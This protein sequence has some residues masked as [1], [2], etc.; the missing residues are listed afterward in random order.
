MRNDCNVCLGPVPVA[1]SPRLVMTSSLSVANVEA[2]HAHLE[3]VPSPNEPKLVL[4]LSRDGSTSSSAYSSTG[5][6][7]PTPTL[8]RSL[9]SNYSSS[10]SESLTDDDEDD[11]VGWVSPSSSEKLALPVIRGL[12]TSVLGREGA[13][14]SRCPS[15]GSDGGRYFERTSQ[16]FVKGL[17]PANH[18]DTVSLSD[19]ALPLTR[20]SA[21]P[22]I[23]IHPVASH[24]SE[25]TDP[26]QDDTPTRTSPLLS[27]DDT[28]S[29]Q[30]TVP[31]DP[32]PGSSLL[33]ASVD[34]P[35]PLLVLAFQQEPPSMRR[36]YRPTPIPK[37]LPLPTPEALSRA[38]L[39]SLRL[40]LS[41]PLPSIP[42]S[43]KEPSEF[44]TETHLNLGGSPPL[45]PTLTPSR[46]TTSLGFPIFDPHP[47]SSDSSLVFGGLARVPR[48]PSI[49]GPRSVSASSIPR[50]ASTSA[51]HPPLAPAP[52]LA[53]VLALGLDP[54]FRR[55]C[56]LKASR[57]SWSPSPSRSPSSSPSSSLRTGSRSGPAPTAHAPNTN[58]A[59]TPIPIPPKLL[60]S[61]YLA[62]AL[63]LPLLPVLP[64][65]PPLPAVVS[66]SLSSHGSAHAPAPN[67]GSHAQH[68]LGGGGGGGTETGTDLDKAKAS[69]R[70]TGA[71]P[72]AT[73]TST[74]RHLNPIPTKSSFEGAT[75]AAGND[76]DRAHVSASRA[77]DWNWESDGRIRT[78]T[79][80]RT[81]RSRMARLE[82][83][84]DVIEEEE[85]EE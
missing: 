35:P 11:L 66:L 39:C 23:I 61:P 59:R 19:D 6:L 4:S 31:E 84:L 55:L 82:L 63:L 49:P 67:L 44:E 70:L 24:V 25:E 71:T 21:P 47:I 7:S 1:R 37:N 74:L 43:A 33:S 42:S 78:R 65:L 15:D 48:S 34:G 62:R 80:P 41:H 26:E 83:E 79:C 36:T 32:C 50:L 76:S 8:L 38:G 72:T 13:L 27:L 52:A 73:S 28:S 51:S 53:P 18:V 2:L 30:Q 3:L 46:H 22:S 29:D 64:D 9:S 68:G 58:P 10:G 60:G 5:L 16:S 12:E 69:V 14:V 40:G 77:R 57:R 85:E 81:S 75:Q 20:N 56:L 45:S 54:K 17:H